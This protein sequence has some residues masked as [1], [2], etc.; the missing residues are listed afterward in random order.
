METDREQLR[1]EFQAELADI[2][3]DGMSAT[4]TPAELRERLERTMTKY[5]GEITAEV[6]SSLDAVIVRYEELQDEIGDQTEKLVE[7]FRSLG[8]EIDDETK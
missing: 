2:G 7:L 1:A 3:R 4:M 6:R 5:L 8:V